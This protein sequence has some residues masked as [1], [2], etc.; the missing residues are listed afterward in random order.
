[1]TEG[2]DSKP[3]IENRFIYH[4]FTENP[5]VVQEL[6]QKRSSADV[7]LIVSVCASGW[8]I[9]LQET[10]PK[11]KVFSFDVN[12]GQIRA[13][14]DNVKEVTGK[15]PVR[16]KVG[17]E[18]FEEYISEITGDEGKIDILFISNIP[19]YLKKSQ[20]SDLVELLT[21]SEVETIIFSVLGEGYRKLD[22]HGNGGL[23][24]DLLEE[25]GYSVEEIRDDRYEVKQ[26]F[27]AHMID[28]ED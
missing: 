21:E 17:T 10:F 2:L 3:Q 23:L 26:Y 18:N 1:M 8:P 22:A 15:E 6:A 14:K 4:F 19:D 5:R 27:L 20:M 7:K 9:V 25:E 24:A 13:F 28:R 12:P 11:A 16:V